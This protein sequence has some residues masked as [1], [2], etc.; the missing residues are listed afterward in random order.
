MTGQHATYQCTHCQLAQRVE[1]R[2]VMLPT[3]GRNPQSNLAM[4]L[5]L[6]HCPRCGHYDRGIE[7]YNRQTRRVAAV[8][9]AILL[10]IVAVTLLAIPAV[11]R[12]ALAGTL[13]LLTVGFAVLFRRVLRRYPVNVERR[14]VAVGHTLQPRWF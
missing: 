2:T 9:Y 12:E 8:G 3:P 6:K 13:G 5:A 11:P 1:V 14:V 7:H 10:G 4:L